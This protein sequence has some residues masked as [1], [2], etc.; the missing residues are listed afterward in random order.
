MNKPKVVASASAEI[1]TEAA[2]KLFKPS[3]KESDET[4]DPKHKDGDDDGIILQI[5]TIEIVTNGYL[6]TFSYDDGT[7]EKYIQDDFDEVLKFIR[8]QH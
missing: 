2:I 4:E 6:V 1:R 7:E 8:S 5:I 3:S